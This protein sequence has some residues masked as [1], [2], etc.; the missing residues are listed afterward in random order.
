MTRLTPSMI[1][2]LSDELTALDR[3]LLKTVGMDLMSLG[4]RAVGL[5]PA[6]IN[7]RDYRAAAVPITSGL[8]IIGGFSRTIA[9]TV[10]DMGLPCFV[11]AATDV[12]GFGEAVDRGADLVLMADDVQYMA[13]NIKAGKYSNNSYCTAAGYVEALRGA[14]H[15]LRGKPVLV[16]GAG[17]VGTNMVALLAAQGAETTVADVERAK[18]AE[19]VARFPG[20]VCAEDIEKA[21]AAADLILN[22]SPTPIKGELIRPGAIIS[23]PGIPHVYDEATLRKA[24]FIHD[25]LAIGTA[26]MVAQA[27]GFSLGKEHLL[28]KEAKK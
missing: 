17:R 14:A 23:T 21:T 26:A 22:A 27:I 16:L 4:F 1:H 18:A 6:G 12:N 10:N 2:G 11:T 24:T 15:G 19:V 13:Y 25:P 20:T 5:D 9:D 3:S 7:L 28:Q 8:G